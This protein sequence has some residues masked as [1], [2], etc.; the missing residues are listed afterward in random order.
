[1]HGTGSK[2]WFG[3]IIAYISAFVVNE[4]YGTMRK[5]IV[6]ILLLIVLLPFWGVRNDAIGA[7][8][9]SYYSIHNGSYR[10]RK[11]AETYLASIQK[12]GLPGFVER[13]NLK[14]KG[15]WYRVYIGRYDDFQ[16][17]NRAIGE[18]KNR[19]V[20]DLGFIKRFNAGHPPSLA[21]VGKGSEAVSQQSGSSEKTKVNPQQIKKLRTR[22]ADRRP[23]KTKPVVP[24]KKPAKDRINKPVISN[25]PKNEPLRPDT[26][27]ADNGDI[28]PA[29][30]AGGDFWG[31]IK[32]SAILAQAHEALQS[33]RYAE[34]ITLL[35]GFLSQPNSDKEALKAAMWMK[36][37]SL[38]RIGIKGDSQSLLKTVDY[39]R[40]FLKDYPDPAEGND[41]I[42]AYLANS[43]EKL[44]F[45]YEAATEWER[46][47]QRYPD[48]KYFEE[49]LYKS[50]STLVSTKKNETAYERLTRY[51]NQYPNGIYAKKASYMLGDILCRM[52][53]I[54]Q[55]GKWFDQARTKWPDLSDIPEA[56][57]YTMGGCYLK[58]ARYNDAF[59]TFSFLVNLCPEDDF[60][61]N[62]LFLLARTAE[63]NAELPLALKLYSV[64][65]EKYPQSK[66]T[67]ECRL[68]MAN[69]G[70]DNPG[71]RVAANIP[72]MDSYVNPLK[73]Y[74]DILAKGEGDLG[75]VMYFKARALEK[76]G[77]LAGALNQYIATR[78]KYPGAEFAKEIDQSIRKI[79][80]SL[81][82]QYY[83]KGDYKAVTTLY[84]KIMD[85]VPL[86]DD[87]GAGIKIGKSLLRLGFY[88]EAAEIFARIR[89]KDNPEL[90]LAVAELDI[91]MGNT[92]AAEKRLEA[93]SGSVHQG[94]YKQKLQNAKEKLADLYFLKGDY[95]KAMV[96]YRDVAKGGAQKKGA[97]FYVRYARI[98][99]A[100][101]LTQE[102]LKNYTVAL[103]LC[104]AKESDCQKGVLSDIYIRLGDVYQELGRFDDSIAMYRKALK[105]TTDEKNKKWLM[106]RL[107]QAY[108]KTKDFLQAEKSFSRIKEDESDEFW[109][110]VAD[111][112]MSQHVPRKNME[113]I[114]E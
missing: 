15:V 43:Y 106:L 74:D 28:S 113:N 24:D 88:K 60:G 96:L 80:G 79:V 5:I 9:D 83:A 108:G 32:K 3:A 78:S 100:K 58:A 114:N 2:R 19:N 112:F 97:I 40:V 26:G 18:L 12:T 101:K 94:D 69:L 91:A 39:C 50:G 4:L 86:S 64:F 73:T 76:Y 29:L 66:E 109:P 21:V 10:D 77:N 47:I 67:I 20:H 62:A 111:F 65:I 93:L 84:F 89:E 52:G 16:S 71:I 45:F 42:H 41:A 48:S 102:A 63:Q 8:A 110:G 49:A 36:A 23:G 31:L 56:V 34:A 51:L 105:H 82:D 95:A 99:Q 81:T 30:K 25:A 90:A 54:D 38:Y 104:E 85:R 22:E 6:Y 27:S 46:I 7:E 14:K 33:E 72:Q 59:E 11:S 92:A 55:A 1:L 107:G 61:K 13:V 87:L 103:Q 17:A 98:L 44:D 75:K 70:V 37:E 68:A 57:L 53:R 35:D